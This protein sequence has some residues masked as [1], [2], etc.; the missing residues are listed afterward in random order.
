MFCSCGSLYVEMEL[1][2]AGGKKPVHTLG[3]LFLCA[4]VEL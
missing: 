1:G 4:G 2:R 3:S